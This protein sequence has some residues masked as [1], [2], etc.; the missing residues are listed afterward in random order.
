MTIYETKSRRERKFK[1]SD[2]LYQDLKK[3]TKYKKHASIL[4][5]SARN[6]ALPVHRSTIHRRIK[7]SLRGLKFNASAHSA[8]KL[9]AHNVFAETHS[10]KKVQEAMHHRNLLP[11]LAYLDI[12]P[13]EIMLRFSNE[14]QL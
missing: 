3:Y 7:K 11:T 10:L 9:Y 4:F 13:D 14:E 1:I 5:C 12:N 6:S 8:R 2:E